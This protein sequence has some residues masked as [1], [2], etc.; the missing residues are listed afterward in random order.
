MLHSGL[1]PQK[2]RFW[3]HGIPAFVAVW[4]GAAKN[5]VSAR[6]ASREANRGSPFP[7]SF[8]KPQNPL[9]AT[10]SSAIPITG[11]HCHKTSLLRRHGASLTLQRP[12]PRTYAQGRFRGVDVRTCVPSLR[13]PN[14]VAFPSEVL[15]RRFMG[16][17]LLEDGPS[18]DSC[19]RSLDWRLRLP[20]SGLL[21]LCPVSSP[22]GHV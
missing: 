22:S 8:P 1:A 2:T 21:R 7:R 3:A 18:A 13:D 20:D 15:R 14:N 16:R 6:P 5:A 17:T 4:A 12:R 10:G 9:I 11:A 19:G